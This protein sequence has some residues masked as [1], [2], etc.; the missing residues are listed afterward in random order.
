MVNHSQCILNSYGNAVEKKT[1]TVGIVYHAQNGKVCITV[2]IKKP[3][4]CG[5]NLV[6]AHRLS[7]AQLAHQTQCFV[8]D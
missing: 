7:S 1:A 3:P 5:S 6:P 4:I 8:D 2:P